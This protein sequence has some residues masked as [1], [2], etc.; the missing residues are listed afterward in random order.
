MTVGQP[1]GFVKGV[2][3]FVSF[4][5][6]VSACF[7]CAKE[8]DYTLLDRQK[9]S[10]SEPPGHHGDPK[11]GLLAQTL[12]SIS[13]ECSV[14]CLSHATPS[15]L[16]LPVSRQQASASARRI[17]VHLLLLSLLLLLQHDASR[18]EP[19]PAALFA[20]DKGVY[21]NMIQHT[22]PQWYLSR[23]AG[24]GTIWTFFGAALAVVHVSALS[25]HA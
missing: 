20:R 23:G 5:C 24:D 16:P 18:A 22:I 12:P 14:L 13:H 7:F 2:L 8:A 10:A 15:G 1:V 17:K 4:C 6:C 21:F 9:C 3:T 19:S 25:R 11:P